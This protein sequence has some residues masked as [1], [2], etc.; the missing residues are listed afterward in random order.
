[1][2]SLGLKISSYIFVLELTF[3]TVFVESGSFMEICKFHNI[4]G[5]SPLKSFI[6]GRETTN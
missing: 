5:V 2:Y 4:L 6:F 1:V 3:A